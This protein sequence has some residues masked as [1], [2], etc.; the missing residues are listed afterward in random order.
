MRYRILISCLFIACLF[1]GAASADTL[2]VYGTEDGEMSRG[3]DGTW[4]QVHDGAG[5]EYSEGAA[6]TV[7]IGSAAGTD[8]WSVIR[9]LGFTFDTSGIAANYTPATVTNATLYI[10]RA[11]ASQNQFATDFDLYLTRFTPSDYTVMA[12]EDYLNF[13]AAISDEIEDPGASG[14]YG[15]YNLNSDGFSYINQSG[16]TGIGFLMDWDVEDTPPAW[17]GSKAAWIPVTL[18]AGSP[19][20]YLVIEYEDAGGAGDPPVASFTTSKTFVRIPQSITFTDTSTETPTSWNWSFGDGTYSTDE[21]P[22]HKYTRR[23]VFNV[24][25][26]ATNDDG[27]DESDITEVK[28]IGYDTHT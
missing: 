27:S 11:T 12:K 13:G 4:E 3:A 5:D 21:N 6:E 22:V 17:E 28:V 25:L 20:P 18:R 2:I 9:R 10:Y 1:I 23:G 24:T 8:V 26:T 7:A 15:G 19:D 14:V 16:Y